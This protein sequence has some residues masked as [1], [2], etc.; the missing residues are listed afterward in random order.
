ML[1]M[2]S[3][4]ISARVSDEVLAMI[5]QL[6]LDQDRSRSWVVAKLVELATK[7]QIEQLTF[8]QKGFDEIEQGDSYTQEEME[9]WVV[10]LKQSRKKAA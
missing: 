8:I 5:D 10:G 6:A 9:A 4:V 7:K 1:H 3:N 2:S